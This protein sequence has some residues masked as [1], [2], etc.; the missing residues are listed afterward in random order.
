[1]LIVLVRYNITST[2]S[3]DIYNYRF[4]PS[5]LVIGWMLLYFQELVLKEWKFQDQRWKFQDQS[6][7]N[8]H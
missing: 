5:L 7:K 6:W 3:S 2:C 4:M 1:M 8:Q